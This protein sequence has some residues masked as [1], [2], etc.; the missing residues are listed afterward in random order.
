MWTGVGPARYGTVS[1][2][3][4]AENLARTTYVTVVLRLVVDGRKGLVH[5]DLVDLEGAPLRHFVGWRGLMR[6]VRVWLDRQIEGTHSSE[7]EGGV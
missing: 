1:T 2:T 3:V 5:G 7:A 6:T 4:G